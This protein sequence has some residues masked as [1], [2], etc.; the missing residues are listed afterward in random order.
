MSLNVLNVV[1]SRCQWIIDVNDDDLPVSLLFVKQGHDSQNFDLFDLSRSCDELS[2]L[3]DIER[4]VITLGFGLG[5][6]NI[7]VLPSLD[8]MISGEKREARGAP[9]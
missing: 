4:V 7:W 9:T 3:A 2:D 8:L 6:E 5:M 1:E